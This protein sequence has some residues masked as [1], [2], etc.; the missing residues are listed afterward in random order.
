MDSIQTIVEEK[1][2]SAEHLRSFILK[3][4]AFTET[5]VKRKLQL[6]SNL[7]ADL[8]KTSK[9]IDIFDLLVTKYTSFL[10]Y[11]IFELILKK[12]G[13][14][15]DQKE[16]TYAASLRAYIEKH[17]IDEF[18]KVYPELANPMLENLGKDSRKL[19]IKLG[20][21]RTRSLS[22]IKDVTRAVADILGISVSSLRLCSIKKGCVLVTLLISTS[23]ADVIFTKD[24]VF[25][26][27]E[28]SNFQAASVLWLKCNG[29][30]FDFQMQQQSKDNLS[31]KISYL[32]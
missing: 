2:V 16:L 5:N 1:E 29:Y 8:Q 28:K 22:T 11:D 24:T 6:L 26:P 3:L 27:E 7:K 30:R 12:Y 17:K 18:M 15:K 21:K 32:I 19:V 23:L 14:E 31:G 9:V 10:D 13:S 4:P 25:S 20:I